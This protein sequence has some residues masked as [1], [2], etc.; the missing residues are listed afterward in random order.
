MLIA[1]AF[2]RARWALH[3]PM[4]GDREWIATLRRD[5]VVQFWFCRP[6][7][8]ASAT[9]SSHHRREPEEPSA[10]GQSQAGV[11]RKEPFEAASIGSTAER[12]IVISRSRSTRRRRWRS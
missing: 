11:R 8:S 7:T 6:I 5:G 9:R 4:D 10:T 2:D 1:D 3:S 12:S